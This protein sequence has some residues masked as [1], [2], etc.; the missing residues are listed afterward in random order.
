MVKLV[1][2]YSI[3]LPNTPGSISGFL[4]RFLSEGINIIGIAS[5]LTDG[6]GIVRITVDSDKS[7]SQVLTRDGFTTID[8]QMLLLELK[9]KPG[10]LMRLSSLLSDNGINI[11]TIYGTTYTGSVGHL[12]INVTDMPRAAELLKD[13]DDPGEEP[14]TGNA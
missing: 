10:M 5:E 2:Q 4:K 13:W 1:R 6:A 3:F 11:T 9:D 14:P 8:T 7:I 12:L